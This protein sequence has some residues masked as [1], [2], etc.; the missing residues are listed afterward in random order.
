VAFLRLHTPKAS[1]LEGTQRVEQQEHVLPVSAL[2]EVVLNALCHRD[3]SV[4]AQVRIVVFADRVE[5]SSP[6]DLMNRLTIAALRAGAGSIPRNPVISARLKEHV[7]REALGFGVR[8]MINDVTAVG[9]PEPE[10]AVL[11]GFFSVTFRTS[12]DRPA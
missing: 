12:A 6:G 1:R 7:G 8:E 5:V 4:S 3:Y 10:F 9:L 11:G 2:R